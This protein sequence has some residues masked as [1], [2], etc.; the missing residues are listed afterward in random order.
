MLGAN[1]DR[2]V[3]R[4]NAL[5][6]AQ[7]ATVENP[8]G[9]FAWF[10]V[11]CNLVYFE[12]SAN[13]AYDKARELGLPQRMFSYQ[14]DPFIDQAGKREGEAKHVTE[15]IYPYPTTIRSKNGIMSLLIVFPH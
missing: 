5:A 1:W 12:Q 11:G 2:D 4:Q 3:N 8:T 7:A 6:R 15:Y 13:V 9:A 10:N 14:F